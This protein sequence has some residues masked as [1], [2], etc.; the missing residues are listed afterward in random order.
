MI[1]QDYFERLIEQLAGAIARVLG[2]VAES[3]YEDAAREIDGC[4]RALG[5]TPV[6]LGR[7]APATLVAM[8]GAEKAEAV[9]KVLDAEAGILRAQGRDV[10]AYAKNRDAETIRRVAGG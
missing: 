10:E 4:Y 9:A 6:M 8:L 7:L 3:K 1:R 5:V 2:L